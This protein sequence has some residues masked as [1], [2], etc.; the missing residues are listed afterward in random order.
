MHAQHFPLRK[1]YKFYGKQS[2]HSLFYV[3]RETVL[4]LKCANIFLGAVE[5]FIWLQISSKSYVS[6]R[7]SSKHHK[8][9][10][11]KFRSKNKRKLKSLSYISVLEAIAC[12]ILYC[13]FSFILKFSPNIIHAIHNSFLNFLT[14]PKYWL[15]G[16]NIFASI[17]TYEFYLNGEISSKVK[18]CSWTDECKKKTTENVQFHQSSKSR[19]ELTLPARFTKIKFRILVEIFISQY[20]CGFYHNWNFNNLFFI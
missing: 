10:S 7:N 18:K 1:I 11:R 20:A 14:F 19:L 3:Y 5:T 12:I 16:V 13:R 15:I 6:D 2:S 4:Q 8:N 9:L 17:S